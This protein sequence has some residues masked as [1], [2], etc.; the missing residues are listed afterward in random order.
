MRQTSPLKASRSGFTLLELLVVI[1]ILAV[2]A[3]LL[4][5]ALSSAR[6]RARQIECLNMKR[7]WTQAFHMYVE[8]NDG[9]IP[10]E[11]AEIGGSVHLNNW[12]QVK[13]SG[14][15]VW[16]NALPD[17][18]SRR[19]AATYKPA[20]KR[21]EFYTRDSFFHCP[22]AKFLPHMVKPTN[23]LALFSI[24]MNSQL[25]EDTHCNARNTISFQDLQGEQSRIVLFLDNL[26]EGETKVTP[27]QENTD[28]GQ[29]AAHADRFSARH[30]GGGNLTFAD[31]H[32]AWFPGNKVVETNPSSPLCGAQILPAVDIVWEPKYDF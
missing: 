31:G 8:D 12:T 2:L 6:E 13:D 32:G 30:R 27:Q 7:N 26:L 5:P 3:A 10:R 25:I 19:R 20:S 17:Y 11:G 16:Y 1:A 29:P 23:P 24:A 21:R 14:D 9:M 15:D 18:L 4:L 28:L 22:S